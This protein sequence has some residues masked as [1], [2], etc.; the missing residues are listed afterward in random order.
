MRVLLIGKY[1]PCQGGIAA[2]SY[3]LS[4]ALAPA[5]ISF[6]VVTIAPERYRSE[7]TGDVPETVRLR[8]ISADEQAPWFIPG[9]ELWT[10]RLVSAAL[11]LADEAQPD[12]V[13]TNYLAP[14]GLAALLVSRQLGV[15]LLL[16]HAGSDMAKLVT[17]SPSR[18]ALVDL[19]KAADVVATNPDAAP[20][21]PEGI[22]RA[23]KLV[24]MPRYL[25]DPLAFSPTDAGPPAQ[26][27][28]L[29]SKLN[30][31]WRLKALDTLAAALQLR[32]GWR[33]DAVADG[34][35]RESFE[36][37]VA[38]QGLSDRVNRRAFV[39]PDAVP[40]LFS[41]ATAVWA[42][43][44]EGGVADFSN[45][46]WEAVACGRPCLVAPSCAEHSDAGLL[47]ASS[48]LLVVDPESPE[49]VAAAL[50]RASFLPATDPPAW[51]AEEHAAYVEANADLYERAAAQGKSP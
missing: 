44:R 34:K 51:L 10:E 4:R 3:W 46:V 25:P 9:G 45:L 29:A 27:L 7:T 28:L 37:E 42:V 48:W 43:E 13:E 8:T 32:P 1:P 30:F 50:D 35:G 31:H 21:L 5:G 23:A 26:R 49:S 20:R 19:L 22:G 16:R 11:E 12:L 24:V 14:F 47:K 38:A 39:P 18:R 41:G 2:G 6:D 17:W 36:A 33:L 15:P 40:A